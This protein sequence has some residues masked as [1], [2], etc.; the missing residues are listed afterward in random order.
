M[1]GPP[2]Y[3]LILRTGAPQSIHFL[4]D[5]P[6]AQQQ[7]KCGR[8]VRRVAC[9][10]VTSTNLDPGCE[11]AMLRA[12]DTPSRNRLLNYWAE[13]AGEQKT[14]KKHKKQLKGRANF[15]TGTLHTMSS[16]TEP[17]S[18]RTGG[19]F[20]TYLCANTVAC[21]GPSRMISNCI[22]PRRYD[23]SSTSSE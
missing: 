10:R 8:L 13:S 5:P 1:P 2:C 11:I 7:I 9:P 21:L 18:I 12:F 14:K 23:S 22:L 15:A 17:D 4:L 3:C 16:F 6:S 20:I 19:L